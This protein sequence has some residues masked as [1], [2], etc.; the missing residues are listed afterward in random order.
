MRGEEGVRVVEYACRRWCFLSASSPQTTT[1]QPTTTMNTQSASSFSRKDFLSRFH[2]VSWLRYFL[3]SACLCL[4][5]IS[6][7]AATVNVAYNSASHIPITASSYTATGNTINFTLNF[8]PPVGTSLTVIRNTGMNYINGEF[9][10]LAHGQQV[11]ISY[12]GQSYYF[13]A[14]YYGYSRRDLV[15]QWA[16]VKPI[17]WGDAISGQLGNNATDDA[18]TP[19]SV[20]TNDALWGKVVFSGAAGGSHSLAVTADGTAVSWGLNTNGQLGDGGTTAS[21]VPVGISITGVPATRHVVAV[22]AGLSHSL[23]LLSDGNIVAWGLNTNGQLGDGTNTQRTSPANVSVLGVLSGRTV[24]AI[25]AGNSHSL[26]LCSDGTVAAWGLNTNGQLGNSSN[27]ASNVPVAVTT[28]SSALSGKNV[29]AIAAG[30]NHSLAL[31]SDG[32]VAAWGLNGNGQLGIGGTVSQNKPF[33]V[34]TAGVLNGKFVTMI[35]G[36]GSHSI[37]LCSDGTTTAWG[38]NTSGQLGNG[39]NAQSSLPVLVTS[40]GALN[41]KFVFMISAGISHSVAHCTDGTVATWGA[42]SNGELGNNNTTSSNVPVTVDSSA[43]Q[44]GGISAVLS[45]PTARHTLGLFAAP[46]I[47]LNHCDLRKTITYSQMS[48]ADPALDADSPYNFTSNA[49]A[50]TMG[51]LLSSSTLTTAV[52]GTGT[53]VYE[54][55]TMGLYLLQTFRTKAKLDAAFPAGS[56]QIALRTS[57]P[58]TYSFSLSFGSDDYPTIPKIT[59]VTNATWNNEAL[60]ITDPTQDTILQLYNPNGV[61]AWFQVENSNVQ[62]NMASPIT[63]FTI[64]GNSLTNNSEF[65]AS[66]VLMKNSNSLAIPGLPYSYASSAYET[67]VRFVV[68]VGTPVSSEPTMYLLMKSHN[69]VQSSNNDPADAPNALPDADL[70]PYAVVAESPVGG[71]LSGPSATSFPLTFSPSGDGVA[72]EYLSHSFTSPAALNATHPSG[73]YTFPG[74]I[75][76]SLPADDYPA[77][78][79]ILTVNGTTPVWNA[80]GQLA[81][82]PTIDNTIV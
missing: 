54:S 73:N 60:K 74:G 29:I 36:G 42:N 63:S 58:N 20:K 51:N 14:N 19:V 75:V 28:V 17:A 48:T 33:A 32:T 16:N 12:S 15:L 26:A 2:H 82:D 81:L 53:A 59:I 68:Q 23:A 21:N 4:N 50:G 64:P 80:Q 11:V 66:V 72:F 49:N 37:A 5:A 65:R 45:G 25:A 6:L 27:S 18:L 41:S 70:A 35:A 3:L 9:D 13:I 1:L 39:N 8:H 43:L 24:V 67:K 76:V 79:K 10:N 55:S 40:S 31:C 57:T 38:W 46:E 78:A 34:S 22:A 7:S 56:Y 77:T 61:D 52:G 30:A 71:T 47:D 44:T 62:S 69:Q